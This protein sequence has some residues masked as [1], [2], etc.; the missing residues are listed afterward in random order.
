MLNDPNQSAFEKYKRVVV[1]DRGI[2]FFIAYELITMICGPMPGA[3]GIALRQVFYPYLFRDCGKGVVFGRNVAVRNPHRISLGRAV[4]IEES[5]TLDAKGVEGGG[6]SIGDGTF[7]GKGTI[8]STTDGTIDIDE[9][10]NLGSNIRIGTIG[11]TRLGKKCLLA[12]YCYLVGAGHEMEDLDTPILDQANTSEGGVT[13]GDN[14]WLGARVTVMDGKTV[15]SHSIVGAHA[16]VTKD[17]PEYSISKG[18]PAEVVR[19]R[20]A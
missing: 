20:K 2:G 6:I 3:L 14:V 16:L 17:L 5:C 19:S 13:L 7:V 10:C 12:A 18:T 9:G 8:I 4:V 1:G 11:H 15:G